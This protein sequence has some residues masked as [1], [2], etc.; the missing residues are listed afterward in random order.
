MNRLKARSEIYNILSLCYTYPDENVGNWIINGEWIDDLREFLCFLTE[1]DFENYLL[2]FQKFISQNNRDLLLELA[3]EYTR[4]FINAFPHVVAPPYASVYM[5]KNGRI[6]G[7]TASEVLQF[8]HQNGFTIKEDLKDLPDHIAHEFE[9]LA[10]LTA[11]EAETSGIDRVRLEEIQ[12]EF[13]SRFILP[14]IN[15]FC[16]R[17]YKESRSLFYRSLAQLTKEFISLEKNYLG[18]PEDQ[19]SRKI[20]EVRIQGG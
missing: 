5:E 11:K 18:I 19:N 6:F 13:F 16:E 17:I 12:I 10:I 20:N 7:R 14:W 3:R 4:L 15:S 1:E 8:Y 9:F 2:N